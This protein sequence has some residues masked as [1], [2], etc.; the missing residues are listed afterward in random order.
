MTK[1]SDREAEI[2]LILKEAFNIFKDR[3]ETYGDAHTRHAN[4]MAA[5]FPFGITL[6]SSE[7][8]ARYTY[9]SAIISKVNRYSQNFNKGGHEDSCIDPINM[10]AM[11]VA[12]DRRM[13]NED[14]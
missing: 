1:L 10:F 13:N 5:M 2:E 8:F 6:E 7:D 4:I 9:I 12:F 3:N 14:S 11:L